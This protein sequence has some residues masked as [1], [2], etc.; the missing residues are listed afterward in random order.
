M[1]A[2]RFPVVAAEGERNHDSI[3]LPRER[4]VVMRDDILN[5]VIKPAS[6]DGNMSRILLDDGES[7]LWQELPQHQ[8][9]ARKEPASHDGNALEFRLL[10]RV[11]QGF[12]SS[13][14]P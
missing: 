13:R 3:E 6:R 8:R 10:T 2:E 7:A 5:P 1:L 11:Q 4:A 9:G 12:E 14:V